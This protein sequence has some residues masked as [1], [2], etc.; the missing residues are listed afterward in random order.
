MNLAV[1]ARFPRQK[2]GRAF[3]MT[4]EPF[5]FNPAVPELRKKY[6]GKC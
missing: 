5:L 2:T 6:P 4:G 1:P 3:R